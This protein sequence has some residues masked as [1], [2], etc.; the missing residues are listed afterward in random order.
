MCGTSSG[1][2][3]WWQREMVDKEW[4]G[5]E[6]L[7]IWQQE[8]RTRSFVVSLLPFLLF[9]FQAAEAGQG[10][11]RVLYAMIVI[12]SQHVMCCMCM[13]LLAYESAITHYGFANCYY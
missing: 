6:S 13:G 2:I 5:C 8:L 4:Q 12:S 3:A 10:Q 7:G 9:A 1:A 11:W